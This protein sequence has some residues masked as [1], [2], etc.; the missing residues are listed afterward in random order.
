MSE[1]SEYLARRARLGINYAPK[2]VT[3]EPL[4]PE[5]APETPPPPK[6]IE[7]ELSSLAKV[8]P[9]GPERYI[10]MATVKRMVARKFGLTVADLESECREKHLAYARHVAMYL[11]RKYSKRSL[12]I[13]GREFGDRDHTT[14]LHG[15]RRIK[16][17]IAEIGDS[18]LGPMSEWQ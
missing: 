16:K 18:A 1:V 13:I 3:L 4:P 9:D 11:C 17:L 7:E 8:G 10:P 12:P 14:V 6:P 2:P 15:I 5:S